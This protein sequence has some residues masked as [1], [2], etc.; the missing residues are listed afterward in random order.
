MTLRF[1]HMVAGLLAVVPTCVLAADP[2]AEKALLL[3]PI[4]AD[5]QYAKPAADEL[6][7]CTIRPESNG[8]TSAWVVY[9]GD[10]TL[11]RR[12][13]DTNGDNKVDRWCYASGGIEVYRDIDTDFNGK[14][15]QYRWFGTAGM[16]WGLDPDEDGRIDSWKWISPEEVSAEVVQALRT[17]DSKRFEALLLTEDEA[18]ELGFVGDRAAELKQKVAAARDGFSAAVKSSSIGRSTKWVDFSAPQPGVIPADGQQQDNDVVAYENVIAMVDDGGQHGQISIGTMIRFNES[19]RLIDVPGGEGGGYFFASNQPSVIGANREGPAV[20]PELQKYIAQLEA[21]DSQLARAS[22]ASQITA[23]NKDRA[24][25]LRKLAEH[26]TGKDRELWLTQLIESISAAAQAGNYPNGIKE[27]ESLHE[28]IKKSTQNNELIA[29]ARFAYMSAEYADGLQDPK[30][31]YGKLQEQ[32][33]SNLEAFV[34]D[35]PQASQSADAMLQLAIAEEFAGNLKEA[36]S[37]YSRIAREFASSELAVKARG[38]MTRINSIGKSIRLAGSTLEGKQFDVAALR[39]NTVLV[40]YWATWCEPCK[41]DIA[42]LRKLQ[43]R[44]ASSRFKIVGVNVDNDSQAAASYAQENRASWDHLHEP[45]GLDSSLAANMGI[46]TV[47]VML[48]L[49]QNGA[50]VNNSITLAELEGVLTKGSRRR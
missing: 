8:D 15:D 30:A 29:Q 40:H 27:L 4:Q 35:H 38:A 42:E 1:R 11:L 46:F 25:V 39:G 41:N 2:S 21:V 10:G 28:D 13:A 44:Y 31:D 3:S 50:V 48:L 26:S 17:N 12:F 49:D 24:D 9:A 14:A 32:W 43:A 47:P 16:R 33:Q 19:W 20:T 6:S 34:K 7:E 22:T 23:F 36:T 18:K 5:V 37:W 45:G